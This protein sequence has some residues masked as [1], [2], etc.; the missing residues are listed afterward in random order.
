[1]HVTKEKFRLA[2]V[3]DIET[4]SFGTF[5]GRTLDLEEICCKDDAI[6]SILAVLA[7][8]KDKLLKSVNAILRVS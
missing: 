4:I 6:C 2:C 8:H 7:H 1:M 3:L 5:V